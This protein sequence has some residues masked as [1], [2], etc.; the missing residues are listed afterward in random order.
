MCILEKENHSEQKKSR[1]FLFEPS[2]VFI[3]VLMLI[4]LVNM[5]V[6]NT[7]SYKSCDR[8]LLEALTFIQSSFEILA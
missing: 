2:L 3:A 1:F 7:L 8:A 5:S 4:L 6:L